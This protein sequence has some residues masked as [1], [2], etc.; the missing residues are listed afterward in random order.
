[1]LCSGRYHFW[2][3]WAI[4]TQMNLIRK[5]TVAF[6]ESE[7]QATVNKGKVCR[8]PSIKFVGQEDFN[9]RKRK[10]DG[11]QVQCK[12]C[13]KQYS[14]MELKLDKMPTVLQFVKST[15]ILLS[16]STFAL[17]AQMVMMTI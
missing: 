15:L 4:L 1:M 17:A 9:Y 12:A 13:F 11:M 3:V 14:L 7:H 2:K 8:V 5:R 16:G 6:V 10:L